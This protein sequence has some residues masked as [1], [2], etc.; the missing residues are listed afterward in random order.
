[1]IVVRI[2]HFHVY[3]YFLFEKALYIR[4]I[5]DKKIF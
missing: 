2:A 5:K 4:P 1:M 3:G